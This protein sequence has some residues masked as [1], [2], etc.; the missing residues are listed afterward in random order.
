MKTVMTHQVKHYPRRQ[1]F[2]IIGTLTSALFLL[3]ACGHNSTP[4]SAEPTKEQIA[5]GQKIFRFDTFGDETKWTD[6]LK[7]H[8]VITAA[9][10]PNVALKVVGLKVDSELIPKDLADAIK[11]GKVPMD[12]TAT[13]IALLELNAVVGLQGKVETIN[14]K[15]TLTK[16]G[17]TCALCHST[18]D[19][20][21]APGIGKRLDG[22]PNRDLDPGL[23]IGLSP[24]KNA[25]DQAKFKSWGPGKF[26]AREAFDGKSN[27]Q[28][29]PPAYGL[30]GVSKISFAGDGDEIAYWNRLVAVTE[31]GGHGTFKDARI[32][33]DVD[34]TPGF[35]D[36]VSSKLA[37]LGFYQLSLAAPAPPAGSFDVAM[38][39]RGKT[40]FSG[41]AK[42]ASCHS[43]EVFTDAPVLHPLTDSMG[44]PE[45][46]NGQSFASRTATHQYRTTP[47]KGVW[48]HAPYFHNGSAATLVNVVEKYNTRKALGLSPAEI[49]D[50]AEYL[51]SL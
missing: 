36:L 15:K 7:I 47:L 40:L 32:G 37:N 50:V 48:Q 14:G 46:N 43:G 23:I 27:A 26:D 12:D 17:I 45:P 11:A 3:S 41:K 33:V 16:V 31:M 19:N 20:S 28:V 2:L 39:G 1:S 34:S 18:V 5:E 13:T 30:K 29:I 8:D 44:E 49:A 22:W 25:N 9:V 21:F 51:K 10:T 4:A 35:G 24:S 38:A 42:C 6:T